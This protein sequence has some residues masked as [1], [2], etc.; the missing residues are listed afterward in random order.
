MNLTMELYESPGT[1]CPY[2]PGR[3]WKTHLFFKNDFPAGAYEKLLGLGFRRSGT[4]FYRNRCP[5]CDMCRQMRVPAAA[6]TPSRSQRRVL[7]RN[8]DVEFS[9]ASAEFSPEVFDLYRRYVSFR[10]SRESADEDS[11]RHFLCESPVDTRMT[12]YRIDGRLAGAGWLDILPGGLSSVYFAFD[13][14]FARRSLGTYSAVREIEFA[15]SLGLAWYYL[16]FVVD[17]SPKMAYKAAFRPHQRLEAGRWT[18]H[19]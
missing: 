14:D 8:R 1:A 11:F 19:P 12:L 18:D 17:G 3:T 13:P 16:G 7:R 9:L 4:Q 6:F 5:G 15:R 2:L 10:H